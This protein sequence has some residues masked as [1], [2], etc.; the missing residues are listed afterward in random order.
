MMPRQALNSFFRS[1]H[2]KDVLW[3][4]NACQLIVPEG[5][6]LLVATFLV[7]PHV[8]CCRLQSVPLRDASVQVPASE[9]PWVTALL[10]FLSPPF[11]P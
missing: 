5:G 7:R 10:P 8:T 2:G 1:A 3:A 11:Q 4:A 9:V 6:A